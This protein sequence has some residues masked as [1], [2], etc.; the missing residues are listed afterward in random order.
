MNMVFLAFLHPPLA[1]TLLL[2]LALEEPPPGEAGPPLARLPV[3]AHV[4]HAVQE[5]GAD[6][7]ADLRQIL[8][9]LGRLSGVPAMRLMHG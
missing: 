9:Q 2:E 7:A 4:E 3:A 8:S 5:A 6:L 1:P